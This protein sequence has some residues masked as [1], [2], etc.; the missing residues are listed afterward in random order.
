VGGQR[1]VSG[2]TVGKRQRL[3]DAGLAVGWRI[4]TG[5]WRGELCRTLYL[6]AGH[7]I[8]TT[9]E[10]TRAYKNRWPKKN[11]PFSSAVPSSIPNW[12]HVVE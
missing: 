8:S 12:N 5:K 2:P 11:V 10:L 3:A 1:R 4:V 7:L 6:L 9:P